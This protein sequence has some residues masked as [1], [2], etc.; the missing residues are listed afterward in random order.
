MGKYDQERQTGLGATLWL[1]EQGY[2]GKRS[3]GGNV[4]TRVSDG[5]AVA[6]TPSGRPCF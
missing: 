1:S 5:T 6:I 4:S 3:S 2:L